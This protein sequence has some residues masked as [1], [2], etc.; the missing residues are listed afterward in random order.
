MI[1][2]YHLEGGIVR[3]SQSMRCAACSFENAPGETVC[4]GCGSSLTT[5]CPKCSAHNPVESKFCGQCGARLVDAGREESRLASSEPEDTG[6][7]RR[8]LTV[9]FCDLVGSTELSVRLDP[10]VLRE[11][12]RRF[13]E[14]AHG[15]I[16]EFGGYIAQY[17]GDGLLVYFGYPLAHEDDALRGTLAGLGIIEALHE[18]N[19]GLEREYGLRIDLRAALHTGLVVT[20]SVGVRERGEDLALGQVPNLAARLQDRAR[21]NTLLLSESAYQLVDRLVVCEHLGPELL[22]GIP[23]PIETYR[24]LHL[25]DVDSRYEAVLQGAP[26]RV[27]RDEQLARLRSLYDAVERGEQVGA[28]I[29]AEAGMGKS[30]L[31]HALR[32]S[33]DSRAMTWAT[34]QCSPFHQNSALRPVIK[35]VE[36]LLGIRGVDSD[37]IRRRMLE[38]GVP[39]L[40][41]VMRGS[42][43]VLAELLEIPLDD[44]HAASELTPQKK[45]ERMLQGIVSVIVALTERQPMVLLVEDLHWVDPTTL[46]LLGIL[47]R[48]TEPARLLILLTARPTFSS[49]WQ[50]DPRV[51]H[52]NLERLSEAE[53]DLLISELTYGRALPQR[54]SEELHRRTDGVP[55]FIEEMTKTLLES[56]LLVERGDT[57]ELTGDYS[58]REIPIALRGSL[59][60]RLDHLAELKELAQIGAMLGREFDHEWI[61]GLLAIDDATLRERLRRLVDTELLFQAGVPP[62]ATYTFKHALIQDAAYQSMLNKVRQQRHTEIARMFEERF[63]QIASSQPELIAHHY[64]QG[65]VA[66]K[67]IDYLHR[68]GQRAIAGSSNQEAVHHLEHGLGLLEGVSDP[69]ER[70]RLELSLRMAHGSALMAAVGYS[71][72]ALEATYRRALALCDSIPEGPERFWVVMG[73]CYYHLVRMDLA[74]GVRLARELVRLS[75][76]LDDPTLRFGAQQALGMALYFGGDFL[77]CCTHLERALAFDT[78]HRN[79]PLVSPTGEDPRVPINGILSWSRWHLGD[80]DR[81]LLHAERA[82]ELAEQ[83]A[84]PYGIVYAH[85]CVAMLRQHRRESE[86]MRRLAN[87]AAAMCRE[88]GFFFE[89]HSQM[90]EGWGL[91]TSGA[92]DAA[93]AREAD[94]VE[95][96][97]EQMLGMYRASGS[98][99]NEGYWVYLVAQAA[100][101]RGATQKA[102][103][104]YEEALEFMRE[105]NERWWEAET[106]RAIG[107]V[108]RSGDPA[109]GEPADPQRAEQLFAEAI[110][111]ARAQRSRALELR[112]TTSLAQL[113]LERGE[114]GRAMEVL[115]PVYRSF[116]VEADVPPDLRAA[117]AV[118]DQAAG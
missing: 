51:H 101:C 4:R 45:K 110:A 82:L 61:R 24:A 91:F 75:N 7:D 42:L 55:L 70:V 30:H 15:V 23:E 95:A 116:S 114:R 60:A 92:L 18:T 56:G 99:M 12:V 67:A 104:L 48:R 29:T 41:E 28:V 54:V 107:N 25:R 81:S 106:L 43:P 98:R 11:V 79:F 34:W 57:Y 112:A 5:G 35:G 89:V 49:P 46:E 90:L 40:G 118:L 10:E 97:M 21:P 100:E 84:F 83:A 72:P 105:S 96:Q 102:L 63:P 62:K 14:T 26:S 50:S 86:P 13:H 88:H 66:D 33:L 1:F 103:T 38:E 39:R 2:R 87:K 58:E 64:A 117:R 37:A 8:P 73:L 77:G 19:D 3:I 94:T 9:L 76:R 65:K 36:S 115:D 32:E 6:A 20:G 68:A 71:A 44:D 111:V 108:L 17:L 22:K 93:D 53:V 78:P 31:V 52:L 80:F 109:H 27:G 47:L 16:R 69:A 74:E 59:T 113:H 85:I